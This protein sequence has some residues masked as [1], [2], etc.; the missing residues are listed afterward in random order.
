MKLWNHELWLQQGSAENRRK[1]AEGKTTKPVGG[2][3]RNRIGDR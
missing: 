1:E 2:R 3:G